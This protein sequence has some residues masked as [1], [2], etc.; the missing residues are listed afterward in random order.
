MKKIVSVLMAVCLIFGVAVLFG[1]CGE[2]NETNN[3]DTAH[4]KIKFTM[5][6]NE[7]FEGGTFIVETY[8]EFA[9]ETCDNFVKLVESGFYDGLT[10][11]RIIPDFMA[12]GGD[13]EGTG[14]GGSPDTIHG[15]F[16][17][18]GFTKNTLKHER[19]VISMARTINDMDSASSQFFICYSDSASVKALD[20]SYAAFGKVIE[21]METVDGFL[22]VDRVMGGDGA[23][24]SPKYQV[25][26]EK[27]EVIE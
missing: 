16:A 14:N 19:G 26:I 3:Y 27:A 9:P 23:F 24:S 1:S 20:G 6:S 25:V 5:K 17:A 22:N 21:G 10:F 12:Q 13:P 2:N 4:H 8:P 18:N 7:Q 15:E 11:H